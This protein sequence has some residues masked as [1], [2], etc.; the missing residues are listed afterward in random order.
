MIPIDPNAF[1]F[2]LGRL[3]HVGVVVADIQGAAAHFAEMYGLDIT[4]GDESEYRCR[5]D[6]AEQVTVQRLGLSVQGP[7]HIE[8]LRAVPQSSV[9]TV[10]PAVHHLG[11]VVDDVPAASRE[12]SRRGAPLW[13]GGERD[14][15]CPVGTAYHRDAFGLTIELLDAATERRITT[16]LFGEAVTA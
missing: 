7:P 13:M 5:V 11:F 4:V 10:G 3:H 6:G 2:D 9:W 1:A 15:T 8:L 14:G 16:R 12:L